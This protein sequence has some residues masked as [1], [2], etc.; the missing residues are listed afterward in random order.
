MVFGLELVQKADFIH[1]RNS[2]LNHIVCSLAKENN[3]TVGFSF[4]SALGKYGSRSMGRMSAN[5]RLCRKYGVPMAIA[6]L[7]GS[8]Y[9]MRS[10]AEL[11]SLFVTLGMHPSEASAALGQAKFTIDRNILKRSG[12]IIAD[13]AEIV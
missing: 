8:P 9:L 13:G 5:I 6:S 12:K 1:Q 10:Q 7:A 3:V 4:V 11:K 2:G